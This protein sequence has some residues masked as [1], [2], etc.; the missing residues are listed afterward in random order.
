MTLQ[1]EILKLEQFYHSEL[2][3]IETPGKLRT[4]HGYSTLC[5]TMASYALQTPPLVVHASRL[6]L[7]LRIE[8][9]SCLGQ[10]KEERRDKD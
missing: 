9:A 7:K 4:R 2:I 3:Y 10:K 6:G 8:H 5:H 1:K